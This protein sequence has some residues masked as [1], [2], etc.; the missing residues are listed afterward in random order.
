MNY[1]LYHRGTVTGE[2]WAIYVEVPP[3][4]PDL[5]CSASEERSDLFTYMV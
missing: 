5:S 4:V 2:E 3:Q 1:L